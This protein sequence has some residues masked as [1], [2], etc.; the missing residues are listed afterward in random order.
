MFNTPSDILACFCLSDAGLRT[1]EAKQ[2][3][4]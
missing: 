3:V 1:F 2:I 4:N